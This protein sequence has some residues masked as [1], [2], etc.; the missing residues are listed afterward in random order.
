MFDFVIPFILYLAV[1]SS[2]LFFVVYWAA[3][4][5]IRSELRDREQSLLRDEPAI[6]ERRRTDAA[7]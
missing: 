7:A 3:R 5:A 6:E 2:C 4:M 1:L